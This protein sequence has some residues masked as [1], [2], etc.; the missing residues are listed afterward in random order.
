MPSLSDPGRFRIN[1]KMKL[2]R[3]FVKDLYFSVDFFESY[4]SKPPL[5]SANKNDLGLTMALAGH[6]DRRLNQTCLPTS[7]QQL[8]FSLSCSASA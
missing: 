3:E 6:A 5:V 4:D 1:L 8:G 7:S 2:K